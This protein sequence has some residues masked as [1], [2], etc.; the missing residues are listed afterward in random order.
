MRA[1]HA[2]I[3]T[4]QAVS[5]LSVA[6]DQL[7]SFC[8]MPASQQVTQKMTYTSNNGYVN[9]KVAMKQKQ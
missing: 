3:I 8:L 1:G 5:L 7:C 4:S 9:I 6:D 2:F